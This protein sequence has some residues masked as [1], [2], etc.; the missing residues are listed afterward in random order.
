MSEF[1]EQEFNYGGGGGGGEGGSTG[2][3]AGEGDSGEEPDSDQMDETDFLMRMERRLLGKI[4]RVRLDAKEAKDL[5]WEAAKK[6]SGERKG[7][8]RQSHSGV[9]EKRAVLSPTLTDEGTGKRRL[10]L[11][12]K[13]EFDSGVSSEEE[14]SSSLFMAR[15]DSGV[16]HSNADRG[17]SESEEEGWAEDEMDDRGQGGTRKK[18]R[19]P[20]L[21]TLE[22]CLRI[23]LKSGVLRLPRAFVKTFLNSPGVGLRAFRAY[24]EAAMPGGTGKLSGASPHSLTPYTSVY[25]YLHNFL[26]LRAWKLGFSTAVAR[27]LCDEVPFDLQAKLDDLFG[28]LLT[29]YLGCLTQVSSKIAFTAPE[30]VPYFATGAIQQIYDR[31]ALSILSFGGALGVN[32]DDTA[33]SKTKTIW[34]AVMSQSDNVYD[35]GARQWRF[36]PV[37]GIQRNHDERVCTVLVP[38]NFDGS[39]TPAAF[40]GRVPHFR[41]WCFL[42]DDEDW[43]VPAVRRKQD[44]GSGSKNDGAREP[45]R[46]SGSG[47]TNSG[48]NR[49]GKNK[50]QRSGKAT[51]AQE[52]SP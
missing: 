32:F 20:M 19:P 14:G 22:K 47:P 17:Q 34:K 12:R 11:S 1:K 52:V 29:N 51:V 33:W 24:S 9:G 38:S 44:S 50:N 13:G 7:T 16:N 21:L 5:A 6:E 41:R 42:R 18:G 49:F 46:A 43:G 2:R 31:E 37:H 48:S 27:H 8:S 15:D 26:I 30:S 45:A 10:I 23:A 40:A 35:Y 4:E 39:V 36:C 25:G 3:P 28:V